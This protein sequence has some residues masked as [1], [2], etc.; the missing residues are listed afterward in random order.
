MCT[1]TVAFKVFDSCPVAVAAN[2]D[3]FLDRPSLPS[4]MR[5]T[6]PKIFCPSDGRAGGTWAG[7]NEHGV[8]AGVTNISGIRPLDPEAASRG[9]IIMDALGGASAEEAV[10]RA[11]K[12][13]RAALHNPFQALICDTAGLYMLKHVDDSEVTALDPGV[14][15]LSNWDAAPEVAEHKNSV[16]RGG[17]GKIAPGAQPREISGAMMEVLKV[18][19]DDWRRSICVHLDT[20]G[21]MFSLVLLIGKGVAGSVW[22]S[23]EGH[24]CETEFE[25][26]SAEMSG[27]F[28]WGRPG[29][30]W[31]IR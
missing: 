19:D 1:L 6:R 20:Y 4:A 23:A 14:H 26:Q 17:I 30:E 13:S 29:D 2:R 16:M 15:V 9:R 7:V 3:E 27:G 28:G 22:L 12:T 5:G 11:G 21:T 25:D 31:R 18:H 10:A 8:F 24:P